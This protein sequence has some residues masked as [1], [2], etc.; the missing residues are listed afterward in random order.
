[1]NRN[2]PSALHIRTQVAGPRSAI[3]RDQKR[4]ATE[5]RSA[6]MGVATASPAMGEF[7]RFRRLRLR[8]ECALQ[9]TERAV[10]LV[11]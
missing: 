8:F 1:V 5:C 3:E 7:R 4:L 10:D 11:L 2:D 6:V 9:R